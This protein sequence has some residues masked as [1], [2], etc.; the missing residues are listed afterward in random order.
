MDT[1]KY[2]TRINLT[3][4]PI[5]YEE[6]IPVVDIIVANTV[7]YSGTLN[8][9]TTF[10]FDQELTSQKHEITVRFLN[11]DDTDTV[12]DNDVLLKDKALE[13]TQLT[14]NDID[15]TTALSDSFYVTTTGDLYAGLNYI[16]WNG[17]WTLMF[18]VPVF[19]WIHEKKNLGWIYK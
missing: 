7:L 12:M 5:W 9:T 10:N 1:K 17:N 16:S 2:R 11:K 8:E 13:V 3:V 4:K 15:C 18:D 14:V 19:T 6:H